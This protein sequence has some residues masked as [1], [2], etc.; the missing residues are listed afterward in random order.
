MREASSYPVYKDERT[1]PKERF[2]T[3]DEQRGLDLSRP[4]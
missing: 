4:L 2:F 1:T 3:V